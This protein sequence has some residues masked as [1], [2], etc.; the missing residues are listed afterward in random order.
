M[1]QLRKT[2][3]AL[4]VLICSHN[5]RREYLTRV[6][7]ALRRQTFDKSKWELLLIDN[8][9]SRQLHE[10]YDLSWHSSARHLLVD[11]LGKTHA[12][13]RGIK[14]AQSEIL[15]IVD[16]DNV[17]A[18]DYLENVFTIFEENFFIG[19]IG[20]VVEGEFEVE[21]PKWSLPYLHYLAI[22][23][24]GDRPLHALTPDMNFYIPP[25]AGMGILKTV[26]EYY[27]QQIKADPV[28]QGLDPVGDELSRAGDTDLALC[29]FDLG[30]ARGYYPQLKLKHLIPKNRLEPEYI[31]RL[32]EGSNYSVSLL[33]LIRGLTVPQPSHFR[34]RLMTNFRLWLR[35]RNAHPL[36]LR[37]ERAEERGRCRAHASFLSALRAAPKRPVRDH[38]SKSLLPP[39]R[40]ETR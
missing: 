13:L 29:A 14:E 38:A 24:K 1:R 40:E 25:G 26:A 19:V 23:D 15:L 37:M 30:F 5:P 11:K 31:E 18:Q 21:P 39:K 20:G 2:P 4:T 33:S 17:L 16:D 35:N 32:I 3:F 9:S 10:V 27:A 12:V 28:R 7:E 36:Q 6:L 8:A 34:H 22:V